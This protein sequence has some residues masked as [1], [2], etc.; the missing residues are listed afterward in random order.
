MEENEFNKTAQQAY[1]GE[2]VSNK[3]LASIMGLS[4]VVFVAYIVFSV[5]SIGSEGVSW[6]TNFFLISYIIYSAKDANQINKGLHV[7]YDARDAMAQVL[8]NQE[9]RISD[10][11]HIVIE[12]HR[13]AQGND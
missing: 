7:L 8:L 4:S 12:M 13:N 1:A 6:V 9:K 5:L 3:L 2:K 10:L 11:E